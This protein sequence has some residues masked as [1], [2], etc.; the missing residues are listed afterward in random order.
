MFFSGCRWFRICI[1]TATLDYGNKTIKNRYT[2]CITIAEALLSSIIN[3]SGSIKMEE[4]E[5]KLRNTKQGKTLRAKGY[6]K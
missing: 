6:K 3:Y 2:G 4:I 5:Q 1:S